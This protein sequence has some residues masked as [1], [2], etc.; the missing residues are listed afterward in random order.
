MCPTL[1][2]RLLVP[3]APLAEPTAAAAERAEAVADM[4]VAADDMLLARAR[5]SVP[6]IDTCARAC[7]RAWKVA[8]SSAG[9]HRVL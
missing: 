9:A 5:I 3:P 6:G 8:L 2:T 1:R 7:V 4:A